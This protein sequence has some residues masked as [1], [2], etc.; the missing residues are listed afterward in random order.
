[1]M[2]LAWMY[3][4]NVGTEKDLSK[5]FTLYQDCTRLGDERAQYHLAHI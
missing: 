1:M 3:Q 2:N 4:N 5:A